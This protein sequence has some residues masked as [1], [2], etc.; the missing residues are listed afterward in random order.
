MG[1]LDSAM[2][3]IEGIKSVV[4]VSGIVQSTISD[5]VSNG[6]ESA[7]RRIIRP[8]ERSLMRISLVFVSVLFIVWGL[9]LFLDGFMPYRGRGFVVGGAAF[10][11][12]GWLF[13]REKMQCN[14]AC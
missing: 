9:A 8:L 14:D 11:S 2:S 12:F 1:F 13:F 3:F 4:D 10:G 6:I 7:F 5:S